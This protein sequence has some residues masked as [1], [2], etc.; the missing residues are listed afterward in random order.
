ME[1]R[2]KSADPMINQGVINVRLER[3]RLIH[4]NRLRCVQV[5]EIRKWRHGYAMIDGGRPSPRVVGHVAD[6]WLSETIFVTR[7]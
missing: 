4:G 6:K 3:E 1:T 2:S 5:L 7:D